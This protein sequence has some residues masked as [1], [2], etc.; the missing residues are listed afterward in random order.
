MKIWA[1]IKTRIFSYR[2]TSNNSSVNTFFHNGR[3][4]QITAKAICDH[5]RKFV[6]SID[7]FE[8]FYKTKK[9]GTHTVRT[10]FAMILH[11]AKV[12]SYIIKMMGRWASD[13]WLRYICNKVPD[14]SKEISQLM[15]TTET[16]F[17]NVPTNIL[18]PN[19]TNYQIHGINSVPELEGPPQET[20]VYR[21]WAN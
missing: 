16:A 3:L 13:A 19:P 6:L 18:H 14:F 15:V 9:I 8:K 21:V 20:I 17:F 10:S 2:N 1:Q 5:L 12:A 7:P 4:V 11:S